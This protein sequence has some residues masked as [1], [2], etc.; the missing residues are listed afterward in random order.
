MTIWTGSINA[1]LNTKSRQT[2]VSLPIAG[3]LG[4]NEF[5]VRYP[6]V[7]E[8]GFIVFGKG[9]HTHLDEISKM[10]NY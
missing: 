3:L 2:N 5:E 7:D 6:Y 9:I 10:N 8:E 4:S 1:I